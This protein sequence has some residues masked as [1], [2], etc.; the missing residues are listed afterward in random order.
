MKKIHQMLTD[1][2]KD[3]RH[4]QHLI[5]IHIT[6]LG[7]LVEFFGFFLIILGSFILGHGSSMV[8]LI[9]QTVSILFYFDLWPCVLLINS[10]DFK[11]ELADN[12]YYVEFLKI[13]NSSKHDPIEANENNDENS[14]N[15]NVNDGMNQE[16]RGI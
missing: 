9:L 10:S 3:V 4:R 1:A 6:I 16:M 12:I 14:G 5:N 2:A 11:E 8:T 7:W 13:F 15:L